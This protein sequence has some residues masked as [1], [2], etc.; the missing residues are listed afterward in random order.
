MRFW[1]FDWIQIYTL[2]FYFSNVITNITAFPKKESKLRHNQILE[3]EMFF[4][5]QFNSI[6]DLKKWNY[7]V[8]PYRCVCVCVCVNS[9]HSGNNNNNV[10]NSIRNIVCLQKLSTSSCHPQ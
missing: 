9:L 4:T 7:D 6:A 10:Q 8:I 5:L 1:V 2:T 3:V